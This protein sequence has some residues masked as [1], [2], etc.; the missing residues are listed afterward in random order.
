MTRRPVTSVDVARLAGVSQSAVSRAFSPEASIS[1]A[2]RARVLEAAATLNYRPS[3]IPA[4]MLSGRSLMIGVIVGGLSNPFYASALEQ[5]AVSLQ[6]SGFQ[7]LLVHVDDAL[8]LDAALNQLASY[9]VDAVITAL[10]I[11]TRDTAEALSAL[12]I[13][14]ICFNSRFVGRNISTITSNNRQSGAM[15]AKIMRECG[16]RFPV[17]LAGPARNAAS[18]ERRHGF[19]DALTDDA[20]ID[21][22]LI[23]HAP[24]SDTPSPHPILE[25]QGDDTYES[26]FNAMRDLLDRNFRPDGLFCS[27]DLMACGAMDALRDHGG[28][29][30]PKD[31]IVIGY[32]NIQQGAW[33]AYDLTTF[34]Q[35]T[36]KLVDAAMDILND[37]FRPG[38]KALSR[39]IVVA[40]A[41]VVRRSTAKAPP[42]VR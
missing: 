40:A 2:M 39:R 33:H 17:W 12:N 14:A 8:T 13:P 5:V 34:D 23:D 20:L 37:A 6:A 7:V 9:R 3:R 22:A 42:Q 21:H 32:D 24:T 41:L 18:R 35:R 1:P 26:G 27:N 29:A 38:A 25:L 15:A 11:G 4:I 31:V 16:V 19:F 10:A 30:C 36:E 28:L